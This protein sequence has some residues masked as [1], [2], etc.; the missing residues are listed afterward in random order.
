MQEQNIIEILQFYPYQIRCLGESE[1]AI[2]R[3]TKRAVVRSMCEVKLVNRK[4]MEELMEMLGLKEPLE[5]IA[6]TNG[7]RWYGH[8]GCKLDQNL[9]KFKFSNLIIYEFKFEFEKISFFQ[10]KF[11]SRQMNIQNRDNFF[12][13]G[14]HAIKMIKIFCSRNRFKTIYLSCLLPSKLSML[15]L[16]LNNKLYFVVI[17]YFFSTIQKCF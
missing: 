16:Q 7:V 1:I 4:N 13:V 5:R 9:F 14:A 2:L 15:W 12:T 10:F 8:Q 17:F 11:E 6:K 3:R